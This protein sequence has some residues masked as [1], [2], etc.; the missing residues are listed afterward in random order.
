MKNDSL[1]S[2]A[3]RGTKIVATLGPASDGK[4]EQLIEEGVDVFRLNF[5]HGTYEEHSA[6][7]RQIRS[8]A[9]QIGRFVAILGD[10][11]G[12]KIRIGGFA[13]SGPVI[14]EE[15]STFIIS[16]KIG[17]NEGTASEVATTYHDLPKTLN[18]GNVLVLGDGEVEIEVTQTEKERVICQVLVA[19]EL[20]SGKGINLKGGGL[21]APAITDKDRADLK[22]A[23]KN[24]LDYLAVSFVSSADDLHLARNLVNKHD[25]ACRIVAKLEKVEAVASDSDVDAIILASD[26]VMVARGDLGIEIGDASLMGMQKHIISRARSLNRCVITATHMM[27]SMVHNSAPTRAEVMDVA[28]A[29]LD[30]TDAVMLSA[31]TAVGS[32]PVETVRSMVGIIEG[33]ESS[34]YD[35][36]NTQLGYSCELI[37][38]SVA[39]A[40]MTV[41]EH[42]SG[43][44]A[45]ACLTSSG[46]TPKL[47]SRSRSRLPIYALCDNPRTLAR[48]AMFRGVHPRQFE[49]EQ[50]DYDQINGAAVERLR[51]DGAVDTGDRIILSKGDYRNVQGGTN[52]MKILEVA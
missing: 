6:R 21:S 23:C 51:N 47:M 24:H 18:T 3:I 52:T 46:N 17:L 19:G 38:E 35:A 42:L 48:V 39:L 41:A 20:R 2:K 31:E 50:I 4:I 14:L 30:G 27:E 36:A 15:G 37:D 43:V 1:T 25:S 26:A 12:P 7:I 9:K 11:Q 29:V 22:F 49:S 10:L 34:P 5:S 16:C 33:A 32:Y 8:A 44:C 45:V 28:N 40:A 13:D